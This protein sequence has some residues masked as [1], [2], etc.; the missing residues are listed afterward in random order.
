MRVFSIFSQLLRERWTSDIALPLSYVRIS[1]L[2]MR[3]KAPISSLGVDVLTVRQ[4]AVVNAADLEIGGP[5]DG[6]G[7]GPQEATR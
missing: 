1:V 5:R 2:A 3:A 6:R 7:F 4:R